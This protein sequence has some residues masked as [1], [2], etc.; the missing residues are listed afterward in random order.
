MQNSKFRGTKTTRCNWDASPSSMGLRLRHGT[1]HWPCSNVTASLNGSSETSDFQTSAGVLTVR[2]THTLH[3][4]P[5]T[6]RLLQV[7]QRAV[8]SRS[9]VGDG[10][11][12][13]SLMQLTRVTGVQDIML[14]IVEC[15]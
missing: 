12:P 11:E 3:R 8:S 13:A 14:R 9:M 10:T 5:R 4:N 2:I 1:T 15:S 6:S 7:S